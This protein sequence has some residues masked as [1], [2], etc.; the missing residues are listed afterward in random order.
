[1]K[2]V[3]VAAGVL[4]QT[5]LDWPGNFQ[6]T[7][8]TIAEARNR[9]V[10]IL[11]LPELS[12]TGYGCEDAFHSPHVQATAQELLLELLPKTRGMII[13]LGLPILHNG[14]LFN[15]ACLIVDGKI[16][17]FVAKQNLAGDGIHYEPRWYKAWP[18]GVQS[19]IE[20]GGQRYPIGSLVFDCGGVRIGFEKNLLGIS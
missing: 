7:V 6:R 2:L 13:S 5:P 4:N 3:R 17:G 1:M 18:D 15:T 12:L 8:E 10:T 11:C 16:A 14:A 9:G 20:L 19:Q